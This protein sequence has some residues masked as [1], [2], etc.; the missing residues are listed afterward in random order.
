MPWN[1]RDVMSLRQEFVLLALQEGANVAELCRRFQISRSTA[2]VLLKRVA[3]EGS[4]GLVDRSRRPSQ[5]PRQTP[6]AI[7]QAVVQLRQEHSSWG[8]RKI[9]TVLRRSGLEPVPHPSTVTS[10][11]RRHGLMSEPPEVHQQNWQ[12]FEHVQ[13]NA[14]WQIDFK[15]HFETLAGRCHPLTLL[16]DHSRYNLLLSA[17]SRF[18]TETVQDR[19]EGVFRRYGI[20]VRINADNGAP[21]GSPSMPGHGITALSIWLIRLG[22]QVS[23]SRPAH[24]QTNGKLERFH[25]SL[26]AEVLAG[27]SWGDLQQVQQAFD[28]WQSIYNQVR[29]H[30]GIGLITPIQRYQPSPRPYPATLPAIEYGPD[31]VVETVKWDGKVKLKGKRLRVSNALRNLPIAFRP[32]ADQDGVYDMYFCH[33]KFGSVDLR[34]L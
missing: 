33:Q 14:L 16:D 19:L 34:Q 10:I 18:D 5:S 30:E 15:G 4:T 28:R 2:Y 1:T 17:C 12:R 21:W 24:P 27:R 13:P 26:K 32:S 9:S 20:P 3:T 11:L 31:D 25:R 29:P 23:H 6:A 22:I 8:G 7:E